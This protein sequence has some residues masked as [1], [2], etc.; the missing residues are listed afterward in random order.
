[1]QQAVDN[2]SKLASMNVTTENRSDGQRIFEHIDAGAE[3]WHACFSS[4]SQTPFR[5]KAR[6][7]AQVPVALPSPCRPCRRVSQALLVDL[8]RAVAADKKR[9]AVA[10]AITAALAASRTGSPSTGLRFPLWR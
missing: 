3:A 10:P 9:T 6:F 7:G 8:S 5:S 1:M 2:H 4:R